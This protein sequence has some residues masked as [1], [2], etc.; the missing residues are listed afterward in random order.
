MNDR[1]VRYVVI[2]FCLM[3]E[4]EMYFSYLTFEALPLCCMPL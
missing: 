4:A 3:F 1:I 2:I